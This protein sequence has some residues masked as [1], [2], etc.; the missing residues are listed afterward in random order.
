MNAMK[1]MA[2]EEVRRM[3]QML[4]DAADEITTITQELTTGLDDVDWTGPD[5]DR[6]RAQWEGDMVPALQ[7]VAHAVS[8]LGTRAE[9]NASQQDATSS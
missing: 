2:V 7:D 6:F 3:A 4:A 8:E 9:S 5:A 1:G